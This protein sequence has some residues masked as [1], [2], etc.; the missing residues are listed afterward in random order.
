MAGFGLFTG[1]AGAVVLFVMAGW[2]RWSAA[3]AAV[4]TALV[5]GAALTGGVWWGVAVWFCTE[6][7]YKRQMRKSGREPAPPGTR[8]DSDCG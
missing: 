3:E 1:V 6:W 8:E 5:L 4:R 2:G 7:V